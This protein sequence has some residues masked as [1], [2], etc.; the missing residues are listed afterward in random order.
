MNFPV[1]S[2]RSL[3][4]QITLLILLF[5]VALL[6][7]SITAFPIEWELRVANYWIEKFSWSNDLTK[8]IQL[9]YRGVRETNL[10][11]PFISYGT[12]WLAFAHL[13]ISVAF[14]GPLR[15]PVRNIWVIEFGMISCLAIFPLAFIC[16]PIRG[17]PFYW[18]LIDCSFG[19]IGGIL[20]W[21]CRVKIIQ[22]SEAG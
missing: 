2:K 13:V 19:F 7:S 1:F 14:I 3:E 16:G 12:D 21:V 22:L 18:Q 15:D 17:I 20:L 8:W 10:K 6:L 4:T 5:I 9:T 11:Y